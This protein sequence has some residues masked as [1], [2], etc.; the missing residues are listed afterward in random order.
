VRTAAR[1]RAAGL[2]AVLSWILGP[3]TTG[4]QIAG[5]NIV[6]QIV[7]DTGGVL[8]GVSV[9]VTETETGLS[10]SAVTDEG[11]SFSFPTLP[12]GTYE[13]RVHLAGFGTQ[14]RELLLAVGQTLTVNF[15]LQPA[16]V[17]ETVVVL[18]TAPLVETRSSQVHGVVEV[19]QI[20][21]LPINGRDFQALATLIPGVTS[22][23]TALNQNFDPVKKFVPAVS[24]NGQNGRNINMSIDGG[25]NNDISMGG[26]KITLSQEAVQEFEVIT[27]RHRA[28][29]GR[30][31][32]GVINV[33]TRRGTNTWRGSV[34]GFFRDDALQSID[35]ISDTLGADKPPF[36]SQ[37]V[38]AT[39]GGAFSPDKA[40]I[41]YSYERQSRDTSNVFNSGG[42]FPTQDGDVIPQPFRQNMNT[43]RF[44]LNAAPSLQVFAR[45]SEQDFTV[46]G[47][48]FSPTTAPESTNSEENDFHDAVVGITSL[49]GDNTV[50]DLRF[51]YA[52]FR[53][54]ILNDLSNDEFPTL[55]FPA[56][57]FGA[58]EAGDQSTKEVVWELRDDFSVRMGNHLLKLGGSIIHRPSIVLDG[59]LRRNRFT[60][61]NNDFDPV[62]RTIGPT[63]QALF[64]RTW[65]S[66][67]F[68]IS[69]KPL[70]EFAVYI[71]DDFTVGARTAL[72]VGVRYDVIHNL[73][74]ERD[75]AASQFVY[76]Q[77]GRRPK[78]DRSNFAGRIGVAFDVLGDGNTV[79]RGGYGRYHDPASVM[80]AT[81]FEELDRRDLEHPPY[82][83]TFIPAA[84]FDALGIV[85]GEP[86]PDSAI[87]EAFDL[88][89]V[90]P[91]NFVNSP[92]LRLASADQLNAGIAHQ[93]T[94][95][96]LAG[97]ALDASVVY[98][99]TTGLNA[100][101]L[102]PE[103]PALGPTVQLNSSTG[104]SE[105]CG[106]LFSA[107]RR[108]D[109]WQLFGSYTLSRAQESTNQ[110]SYNPLDYSDPNGQSELGPTN[111]DE[112]H[113]LVVSGMVA[114]PGDFLFSGIVLAASARPWTPGCDC[115]SN[116]DGQI[117]NNGPSGSRTFNS[118]SG[119]RVEPR[120]SRRGDPTYSVDVRLSKLLQL[121]GTARL[122][123]M[124]E[125]F[126]LFDAANLG[127]NIFDNVEDPERFGTP[128]NI[129]TP[130][131][132]AQIGVRLQF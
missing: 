117:A 9:T 18:A 89:L 75:V 44:D 36:E 39:L 68:S 51:H 87:Q 55:I 82:Q 100:V 81:L 26:Q 95:G 91:F 77:L 128:I 5:G 107:R 1:V 93:L 43:V 14:E 74:Y 62:T 72:N 108:F 57:S 124:F 38:G 78:D 53:N 126:N 103:F 88:G 6:G 64:L 85:A 129:I 20:E 61:A 46:E 130:P 122:E 86:V 17:E 109:I 102:T 45:Y 34:F 8:P 28:E 59:N 84:L 92:D 127:Q 110:F 40:F 132:T 19:E 60:F 120:G 115:D 104:K 49:M 105:Y 16:G 96:P 73:F 12:V 56:A 47:E 65:S 48:L 123:L 13:I 23:N 58:S 41:F 22:G 7:D 69:N 10:R 98:S 21:N 118:F 30:G 101:L 4:A 71:Q 97:L 54:R 27:Q 125:V 29:H 119:D 66:P 15:T 35:A 99:R 76:D 63:N 31:A 79:I 90:F 83:F 2:V 116:G 3:G 106:L 52:W 94:A 114:L 111:F 131:R 33:V 113:R 42:A 25:D 67:S 32:G 80:A 11:G 24:I 70:T 50:N 121:G 37:Q 112:R